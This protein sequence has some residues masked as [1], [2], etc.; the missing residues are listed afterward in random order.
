MGVVYRAQDT[1]LLREVALKFLPP[2]ADGDRVAIGRLTREARTASAL[3]HPNICTVYEIGEHDGRPFIAMELVEGTSLSQLIDGHPLEIGRLLALG[4][5]MADA[6]DAAHGHGILHRDIKPSNVIVT[7]RGHAK[8][9]DFGLA[10]VIAAPPRGSSVSSEAP[11]QFATSPGIVAGTIGYMSP[12]QARGQ[13]LDARSDLFSFGAVLYE[14]ATG[15]QTFGGS[16]I[17]VVI[18]ALLNHAPTPARQINASLPLALDEVLSK[19]LEK[20]RELRYQTAA[21][22][23]ADLQRLSRS[24]QTDTLAAR[25]VVTSAVVGSLASVAISPTRRSTGRRAALL[26]ATIAAVAVTTYGMLARRD[27]PTSEAAADVAAAATIATPTT[28]PSTPALSQE[29]PANTSS[30]PAPIKEALKAAPDR[31]GATLAPTQPVVPTASATEP[32]GSPRSTDLLAIRT[33]LRSGDT[34]GALADVRDFMARQPSPSPIEAYALLLEIH[35]RR[36]DPSAA[37]ATIEALTTAHPTNPRAADLLL[38][39]ARM[40]VVRPGTGQAGRLMFAR[41]LT[42]RIG[43]QYPDSAA[44]PMA[45]QLQEQVDTR[46]AAVRSSV[47]GSTSQTRRAERLREGRGSRVR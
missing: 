1:R 13:D 15:R 18:D 21:D 26:V 33:K 41:Q 28:P 46:L 22:L 12:E 2:E 9:L 40:Q 24:L 39:I 43:T 20:D 32:A 16:T 34:D 36:G 29:T 44:A 6:L 17:G 25:T 4:I 42:E 19:A 3:N 31:A 45:K 37:L 35:Q 14:M 11:T 5:E 27:G 10:K 38:Q 30:Q 8:I 47:E 7:A 23:R